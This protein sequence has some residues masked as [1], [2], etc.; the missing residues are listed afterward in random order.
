[1][2]EPRP[3]EG[4]II[5][6]PPVV[7]VAGSAT[8]RQA[9]IALAGDA[10]LDVLAAFPASA[11]WESGEQVVA[12]SDSN[13]GVATLSVPAVVVGGEQRAAPVAGAPARAYLPAGAA[14]RQLAAAVMAVAAGLYA[15]APTGPGD[16]LFDDLTPRELEVLRLM[17]DGLANRGIGAALGI[18]ENT[19]KFHV[20]SILSK[21]GAQSRAEAVMLAV[22]QGL[23]PL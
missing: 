4:T 1:V 22:R 20:A 16:A 7:V 3:G 12:I 17:A 19:V 2:Q 14:P 11:S 9:L 10:G 15:T 23:L 8:A 18:S 21:L 6:M 5:G 13:A